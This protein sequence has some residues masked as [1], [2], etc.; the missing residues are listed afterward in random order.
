M[1]KKRRRRNNPN[2]ALIILIALGLI[3]V[4]LTA[5]ESN[6]LVLVIF[7]IV[8]VIVAA[9]ATWIFVYKSL[10]ANAK[11]KTLLALSMSDVDD[12]SGLE[13]ERYIGELLRT[14]GYKV[15]FT[16]VNDFGVDV[17]A[18]KDAVSIA[19]QTKRYSK[20]V[21][22]RAVQEAY[23]GMAQ[24]HCTESMVVTNN[25][26]TSQAIR[27]AKV[28]R[29]KLVDRDELARWAATLDSTPRWDVPQ[30]IDPS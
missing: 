11:N 13:F 16:P 30:R 5:S 23:T 19:I 8:I 7:T 26:F 24:H 4:A 1:T 3:V 21:G 28:N 20:S 27:L 18:T 2:E 17:I 10:A 25:R 14:Q 12:M 22:L 6:S 9:I 29:C 15:R